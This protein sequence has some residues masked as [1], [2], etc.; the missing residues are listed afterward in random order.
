M[1]ESIPDSTLEILERLL[2]YLKR[3]EGIDMIYLNLEL[4][5]LSESINRIGINN[6]ESGVLLQ[7]LLIVESQLK[8]LGLVSHL[9]KN[10]KNTIYDKNS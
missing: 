3:D 8:K 9:L 1:S 2:K 4:E 10:M 5:N 7:G 6:N